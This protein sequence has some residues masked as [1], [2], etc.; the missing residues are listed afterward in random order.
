[1]ALFFLCDVEYCLSGSY[2]SFFKRYIQYV[3]IYLN[4]GQSYF[5]GHGFNLIG[6]AIYFDI[7]R[8][9]CQGSYCFARRDAIYIKG[10]LGRY[11]LIPVRLPLPFSLHI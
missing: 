1:M 10:M 7:L 5:S 6:F 11:T 2:L 3:S 8:C 4:F 9:L